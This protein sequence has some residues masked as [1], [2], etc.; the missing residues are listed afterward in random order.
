M[1]GRT[2]TCPVKVEETEIPER[3]FVMLNW[4]SANRDEEQ[5]AEPEEF[6]LDRSPNPHVAF[7][8]GIHAC[9]GAQLARMELQSVA[10]ELLRRIPDIELAGKLPDYY[11]AGGNLAVLPRLPVKFAAQ[12]A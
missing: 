6:R 5:F 2:T 1:F 10:A 12:T 11:F 4:S 7:G 9:V 8:F 3:S